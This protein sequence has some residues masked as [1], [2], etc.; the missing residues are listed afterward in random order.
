MLID[1]LIG[2]EFV[3]SILRSVVS[4]AIVDIGRPG[5]VQGEGAIGFFELMPESKVRAVDI[6]SRV[7]TG[8]MSYGMTDGGVVLVDCIIDRGGIGGSGL[9]RHIR[10]EDKGIVA[11]DLAFKVEIN[12]LIIGPGDR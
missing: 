7:F 8:R 5:E 11:I 10:P 2:I 3:E 12:P 9:D 6:K 4:V 1:I